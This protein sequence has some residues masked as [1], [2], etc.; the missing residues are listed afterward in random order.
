[1]KSDL[2]FQFFFSFLF[3]LFSSLQSHN[4]NEISEIIC[5]G[6]FPSWKFDEHRREAGNR[7][8]EEGWGGCQWGQIGGVGFGW[9]K[10]NWGGVKG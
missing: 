7:G 3:L 10:M 8:R 2:S 6:K 5:L 1:M 4:N 9:F